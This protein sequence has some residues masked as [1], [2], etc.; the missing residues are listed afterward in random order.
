M[1]RAYSTLV[2]REFSSYFISL[3]GYVIMA[4]VVMLIG[5]SFMV[6][7]EATNGDSI[8]MPL[9]ELFYSTPFFWLI[10]I[11]ATPVMTMR[12]FALERFTGTFETLMTAPVRDL[13]VVLAKFTAA[14]MFYAVAWLPLLACLQI[15]HHYTAPGLPFVWRPVVSTY[16]G[17]LLFGAL[18]VAMGC[19]ASAMTRSQIIAAITSLAFGVFL[20]L[21]SFLKFSIGHQGGLAAALVN[22]VCLFDQMEDFVRG[23][24]DTRHVVFPLSLTVWFLFLTL[25]TVESRRWK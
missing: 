22:Y 12:L 5:A 8:T 25:K 9:T 23:V 16:A 1:T 21:V 10:L 15:V 6:M 11:L 3:T 13:E 7:I 14:M 4:A 20:F 17:I 24:I 18:Y 19:L 2:R